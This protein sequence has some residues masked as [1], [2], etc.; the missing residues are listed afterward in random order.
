MCTLNYTDVCLFA[1]LHCSVFSGV[2][3]ATLLDKYDDSDD[4][5]INKVT[6]L[7]Y[8]KYRVP[9]RAHRETRS[10]NGGHFSSKS[11]IDALLFV[12]KRM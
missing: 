8:S 7:Q 4:E 2:L 6:Y 12:A 3:S 11:W 1:A 5:G 9:Q 10:C